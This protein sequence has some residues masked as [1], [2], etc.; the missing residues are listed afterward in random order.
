MSATAI[1]AGR[2][3]TASGAALA[4]PRCGSERTE[5]DLVGL[6]LRLDGAGS[7]D[8]TVGIDMEGHT[9]EP[10]RA[11]RARRMRRRSSSQALGGC[12]GP[13]ACPGTPPAH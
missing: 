5:L 10:P 6:Q 9:A 12:A 7:A 8:E 13:T 3:L 2:L 4:C 1:H 11:W